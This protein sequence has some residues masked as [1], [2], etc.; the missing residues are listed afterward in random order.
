MDYGELCG[1]HFDSA[2]VVKVN[3]KKEFI[4][5]QYNLQFCDLMNIDSKEYLHLSVNE[6]Q[7]YTQSNAYKKV[8]NSCNSQILNRLV[9]I[10]LTDSV[11]KNNQDLLTIKCNHKRPIHKKNSSTIIGVYTASVDKTKEIS[12]PCLYKHYLDFFSDK[13][14]ATKNFLKHL[15]IDNLFYRIPT[16]AE[17]KNYLL[18]G[19]CH[20]TIKEIAKLSGKSGATLNTQLHSFKKCL[21]SEFAHDNIAI[22]KPFLKSFEHI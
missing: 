13:Q 19:G 21:K 12:L 1:L 16:V 5:D 20:L 15:S 3:D 8:I 7:F 10:C 2:S 6:V 14:K 22:F 17:T 11:H 9:N 18:I 4:Y